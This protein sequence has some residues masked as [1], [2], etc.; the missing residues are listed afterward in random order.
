MCKFKSD[1][2]LPLGNA[3][4]R[5]LEVLVDCFSLSKLKKGYCLEVKFSYRNLAVWSD[6]GKRHIQRERYPTLGKNLRFIKKNS[7]ISSFVAKVEHIAS[8]IGSSHFAM[9]VVGLYP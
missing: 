2:V 5:F 1:S 3:D 8:R 7:T 4:H 9:P 6:L